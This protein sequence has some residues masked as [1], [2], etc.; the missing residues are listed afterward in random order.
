[1][2]DLRIYTRQTKLRLVLGSV[3]LLVLVGDGLILLFYGKNAA[4]MGLVCIGFALIP[5]LTIGLVLWIIE[6]IV[7]RVNQKYE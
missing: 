2:R 5:V 3:V 4:V 7:Q 1:M 6:K